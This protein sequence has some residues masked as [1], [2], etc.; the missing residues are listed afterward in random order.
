MAS[1]A[2][3]TPPI[4]LGA[5]DGRYRAAVAP[6]VDHLSEPALNRE[7]VRVEVEWLIHLT[8]ARRSSRA[9]ARLTDGEQAALRAGRRATSAPTRSPSWRDDRA[10]DRSTTSRR[11]STSSSAASTAIAPAPRTG[12]RRAHPLLLHQR[13]HQ[14][15]LLRAHGQ[16]RGRARSGCRGPRALVE[17]VADDGRPTCATC[18]C[19]RTPTASRRPRR[20]WARS[21]PSSPHRLRPPAAPH[22]RRRVPRQ[23]QRRDRHLRRP[24][25]RRA[26]R[27]LAGDQPR[28]SSRASGLQLE[29]A[30]HPDRVARLAGRALRRRRPVQPGAAQPL[31]RRL[32]LHLARLLRAGP[33][34]GHGRLVD[35]AAQGQP[36]PLRERRGQPRGVA[37]RCSTCWRSTLVDEPAAARPHRL[38]DAAQHR[39]RRSATRCSRIDNVAR[40]LAGPR[41]RARGDGRRPRRQL[42]G[43]RR[44]GPVGDARPRRRRACRAWTNPTSGSR[45]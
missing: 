4:A 31:H 14:Q 13:G 33:R 19:S 30:H 2:D 9:S 32:D 12:A 25:R 34:P 7:R 45:S 44:A 21:S 39:R 6:L 23:A 28:R 24:P 41:R 36:D 20:R 8:D 1:L 27:R 22:R 3:A 15:P 42:G 37:T 26:R 16:G 35:D 11:S 29:P 18:R 40:G 10:G 38:L 43:A 5:L 17:A